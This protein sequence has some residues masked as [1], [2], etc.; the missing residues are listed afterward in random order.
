MY[1]KFDRNQLDGSV[2]KISHNSN[3]RIDSH[4]TDEKISWKTME[5][6][7]FGIMMT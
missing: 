5:S 1:A 6:F 3:I 7:K 2:K 4:A